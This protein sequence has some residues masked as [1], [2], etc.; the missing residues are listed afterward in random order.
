MV[1]N[2]KKWLQKL[3]PLVRH[4]TDHFFKNI[5]NELEVAK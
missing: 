4:R 2:V 5:D 1:E 3:P